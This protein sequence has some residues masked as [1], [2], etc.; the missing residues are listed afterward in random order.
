MRESPPRARPPFATGFRS[1][2]GERLDTKDRRAE[3]GGDDEADGMRMR[4]A[5]TW[6]QRCRT[7]G[8][9]M[10]LEMMSVVAAGHRRLGWPELQEGQISGPNE[11][12]GGALL[13]L[14]AHC[15]PL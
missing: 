4:V 2:K 5:W 7:A 15:N 14:R 12:G 10:V 11:G 9:C 13:V 8:V 1:G 6:Q 3:Y